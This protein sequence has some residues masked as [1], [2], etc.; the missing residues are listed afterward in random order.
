MTIITMTYKDPGNADAYWHTVIDSPVGVLGLVA[1][2]R[3]LRVVSWRD[4]ES[5]VKLPDNIAEDADHPI[6]RRAARQTC[7]V[8]RRQENQF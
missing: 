1:T 4:E 7:R 8:F 6:L 5:S 3:G 2:R